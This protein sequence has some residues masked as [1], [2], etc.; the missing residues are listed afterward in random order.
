MAKTNFTVN[1]KYIDANPDFVANGGKLDDVIRIEKSDAVF[2]ANEG[3]ESGD[4]PKGPEEKDPE[5]KGPISPVV[6]DLSAAIAGVDPAIAVTMPDV[7]EFCYAVSGIDMR[8]QAATGIMP[9]FTDEDINAMAS[10][11]ESVE[12]AGRILA[13]AKRIQ[14]EKNQPPAK[15]EEEIAAIAYQRLL[16]K[17]GPDFVTAKKGKDNMYFSRITWNHLPKGKQGWVEVT[18]QMP[19]AK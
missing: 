4:A 8:N 11:P 18:K 5:T 19:E 2:Y 3:A 17:Y 1:Q 13:E 15:T 16:T 7:L 12:I 14:A 6:I 9:I 10:R